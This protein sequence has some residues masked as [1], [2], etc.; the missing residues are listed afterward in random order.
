M[1]LELVILLYLIYLRDLPVDTLKI[2]RSFVSCMEKE[3]CSLGI[4]QTII[5]L[6]H[7]LGL[8][9]IAQGVE[10][11]SQ[12]KILRSLSWKYRQGYLFPKPM[13]PHQIED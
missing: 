10:T 8:D 4:I 9:V 6:A 5:T 7:T 1:I 2:N 12:M 11:V 3:K 13:A